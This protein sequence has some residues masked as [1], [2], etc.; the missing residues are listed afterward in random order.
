[1]KADKVCYFDSG[2]LLD[3]GKFGELRSKIPNFDIQA[4]LMGL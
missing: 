4:K 3:A 1:M 2:K